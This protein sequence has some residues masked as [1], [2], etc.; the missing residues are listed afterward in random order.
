MST[1]PRQLVERQVQCVRRRLLARSMVEALF[2]FWALGFLVC[3]VWFLLRPFVASAVGDWARYGIPAGILVGTTVTAILWSSLKAPKAAA[4]ALALDAEFDLKERVTTFTLLSQE[5]INSPAGTALLEDVREKVA[6][7]DVAGRFPLRLR[8]SKAAMPL[9]AGCLALVA[10]FFDPSFSGAANRAELDRNA[11]ADP[12]E[13]QQQLD[14]L[15]KVAKKEKDADDLPKSKEMEELEKEWEKL[16]QKPLDT[17]NKEKVRER[18]TELAKLDE[19]IQKRV[20]DMKDN[21]SNL[22]KALDKLQ[23]DKLGKKLSDGPAKDLEDALSKGK[24]DKVRDILEK[25]QK[26][27]EKD[28]LTKEEQQKL[29]EQLEQLQDKLKRLTEQKEKKDELQKDFEDGKITKEQL[30]RELAELK[31]EAQGLE[32]LDDLAEMLGQCKECLGAGNN[33]GAGERIKGALEKIQS[34][35]LSDS[36]LKRLLSDQSMLR[37]AL[38]AMCEACNGDCDANGFRN[39]MGKGK[40]PGGIRPVG[41]EP[42]SKDIHTPEKGPSDP[43]GQQ[44]ITGF[45]RGGTFKKIPS[46]EVGGAFKRADQE[47]SEA[48][49]RQ[50]IPAEAAPQ[51]RGYFKKLGGQ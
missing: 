3:G 48:I 30:D 31:Q 15:R 44:F 18:T 24:F 2:N 7:L 16:V 8:L 46:T 1:T 19:K 36:E 51:V 17:N 25:L 14:N 29:A 45:S 23:F 11:V 26:D 13:I 43:N 10:A 20:Q 42:D 28:K 32:D 35:D 21:K 4:A 41:E 5:Q 40:N 47:S 6:N 27:L 12:K 37:N 38:D 22:K 49:E 9:L 39:G 50:R 33:L 34:M